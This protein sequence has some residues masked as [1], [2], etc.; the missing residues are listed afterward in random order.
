MLL[1]WEFNML[2]TIKPKLNASKPGIVYASVECAGELLISAT[3][4][5]CLN[6]CEDRGY[7][8]ENGQEVLMWL[9]RNSDFVGNP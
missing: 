4:D 1:N 2:V 9:H 8:I 5:Y 6:A 3:L 7:T